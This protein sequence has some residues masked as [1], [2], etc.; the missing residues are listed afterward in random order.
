M[1][2]KNTGDSSEGLRQRTGRAGE[3]RNALQDEIE[4]GILPP[5]AALD[6]RALAQRFQVSRTPVREALQ[7]LAERGL[8][9]IA[10]RHGVSVTRLTVSQIRAIMELIGEL[11]SLVAKLAARRVDAQLQRE[12][13][14]AIK[15]CE[16]AAANGGAA[17][18]SVANTI[19]HEAIY[20][21]ARNGYLAELI[22]HAR[23]QIM[24]YRL[25]DFQTKALINKSLQDHV[26]VARAIQD[27]DEVLAAQA[28]LLHVPGGS[29]GFSEFLAQMPASFFEA[30]SDP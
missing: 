27:G 13:D 18:Y 16:D 17:E 3:I 1:K 14:R 9:K 6:E 26:K 20:A 21:G 10:P 22:R 5:G 8:V 25:S 7:Q 2:S 4:R 30:D 24:R 19:F 15:L 12:L 23:Q 11:E 29:T 28:M